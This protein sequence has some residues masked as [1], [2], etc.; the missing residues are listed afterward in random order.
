ME[1][2]KN[3]MVAQKKHFAKREVS[4]KGHRDATEVRT[5]K[6]PSV[7]AGRGSKEE[8]FQCG[9]GERETKKEKL[10]TQPALRSL[11]GKGRQ[12]VE[13]PWWS[14]G[15]LGAP[16]ILAVGTEVGRS[17]LGHKQWWALPGCVQSL[18]HA[19]GNAQH[20]YLVPHLPGPLFPHGEEE[21]A[22]PLHC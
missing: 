9:R 1:A 10:Y 2:R 5:N 19:C 20:T 4:S 12:E 8:Q 3:I 13:W 6:S 11:A 7:V 18:T 14:W 16:G 15:A 22:R 17:G 21:G